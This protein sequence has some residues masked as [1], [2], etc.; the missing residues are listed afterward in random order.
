MTTARRPV[1]TASLLFLPMVLLVAGTQA[2]AAP[3]ATTPRRVAEPPP[4]NPDEGSTTPVAGDA[5]KP[6]A[7]DTTPKEMTPPIA[8]KNLSHRLQVSVDIA[9]GVGAAFMITYE[10][11]TWCGQGDPA[12][13][14][15]SFCSGLAP[16]YLDFGLGFSVLHALDI[17]ADFRL[18]VME[19]MVGNRPLMLMPGLRVWIDPKQPFKIGLALQ[20][21]IDLTKQDQPTN[22]PPNGRDLDLG[23]RFYAQFQYDFLRYIGLFGRIGLLGTFKKWIGFNLEAQFG[24]QARFP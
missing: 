18:G 3:A 4:A 15:D 21:V 11:T 24:V 10:D 5:T 13:D 17:V 6:P 20:M 22:L 7:A 8:K 9:M 16:V 23:V 1:L 14:N 12:P 19:D 2:Q